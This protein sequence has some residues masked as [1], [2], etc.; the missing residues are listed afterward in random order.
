MKIEQKQQQ[1][2]VRLMEVAA[3]DA[4]ARDAQDLDDVADMIA[5]EATD[6]ALAVAQ[7]ADAMATELEQLRLFK[8]AHIS[9]EQEEAQERAKEKEAA[10][11]VMQAKHDAENYYDDWREKIIVLKHAYIA[12]KAIKAANK[13]AETTKATT[14][15]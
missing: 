15:A 6:V 11:A 13:T 12:A 7:V 5:A 10:L 14:S 2:H 1:E 8:R 3:K 9:P 4:Q